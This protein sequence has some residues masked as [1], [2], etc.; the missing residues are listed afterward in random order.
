MKVLQDVDLEKFNTFGIKAK[1]RFFVEVEEEEDFAKLFVLEEFKNNSKLFLGGGSNVLFTKDFEG[2]VILNRLKGIEILEEDGESVLIKSFG[3]EVWDD[4]VSFTTDRGYWGIENLAFIPGTV[5]GAPMQNIGA[6]GS[7]LKDTLEYLEAYDIETGEK[8]VF[9]NRE[10][11]FGYRDSVFKNK[12]KGKYF[13]SAIVLKLSKIEKK[14]IEYKVLKDFFLENKISP[15]TSKIVGECVTKIRQSKLPDPKVLGNA[16]SFFKNVYVGKEKLEN[17]LK[18]YPDMPYFIEPIPDADFGKIE[19]EKIKI[20]SAWLIEQCG[21]KGKRVGNVGMH[22][23][24]ALVLVNYG[25]ATG[26]EIYNFAKQVIN[27]VFDKFGIKLNP[28]VNLI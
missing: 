21:F 16:G 7:E 4:L 15:D 3:G 12:F 17:L 19:Q 9:T 2:I 27:E 23:K 14:N 13:I 25:G 10:C 22:T 5:G 8:K 11:E 6:Y 18:M 20:P 24:Q 26:E 28:E 1:A